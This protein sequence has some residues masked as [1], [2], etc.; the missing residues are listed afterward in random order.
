MGYVLQ[1]FSAVIFSVPGQVSKE[2]KKEVLFLPQTENWR[3]MVQKHINSVE[4]PGPS[5]LGA[6]H[7]RLARKTKN[8]IEQGHETRV[9]N[10]CLFASTFQPQQ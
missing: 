6:P 3:E 5:M 10:L 2:K 1:F 4:G 7:P 9:E 8:S